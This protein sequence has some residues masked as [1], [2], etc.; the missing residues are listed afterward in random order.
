MAQWHPSV[1]EPVHA[2]S[3][4]PAVRLKV[5]SVLWWDSDVLLDDSFSDADS[6]PT[7]AERVMPDFEGEPPT[8]SVIMPFKDAAPFIREAVASVLSQSWNN[9]DLV[10]VDDG[11]SD[12]SQA[13]AREWAVSEPERVRVVSHAGRVSRGTGPSRA[14]GIQQARGPLVAFLDADDVW[15]PT[16]LAD[17]AKLLL[18]HPEAGMVCGRVWTW[19]SWADPRSKDRAS[20][21]AFAPGSVV[22]GPRLLAAVLRNGEL[23]TTPCSLMARRRELLGCLEHLETFPDLYEDQVINSWLQMRSAAVMNGG[24]TAWYRQHPTSISARL[25]QAPGHGERAYTAFLSWVRAQVEHLPFLDPEID[26][27]LDRALMRES[28]D[29]AR[30]VVRRALRAATPVKV[31]RSAG[32]IRRAATGPVR[33]SPQVHAE[34]TDRILF[35]NGADI[36]GDVLVL[37]EG[38]GTFPGRDGE[39]SWDVLVWPEPSLE[40]GPNN[41]LALLSTSAYDCIIAHWNRSSVHPG[42]LSLRHLRRVL[43][44][45]GVLLLVVPEGGEALELKLQMVFGWDAVTTEHQADPGPYKRPLLLLRAVVAAA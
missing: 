33:L 21:L 26:A 32:D 28:N 44:P 29:P 15:E 41:G 40:Q 20:R 37:G 27:L 17:Y 14:L 13:V 12:G 45:G 11:G 3:A 35:R 43:R 42:D 25:A 24:I 30:S 6:L 34:R 19:H 7:A 2:R 4:P 23:A 16:H 22:A 10:L 5:R 9:I 18:V 36:R 1:V 39:T 8:I 38:A 31:R